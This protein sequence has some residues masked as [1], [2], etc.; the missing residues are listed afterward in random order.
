MVLTPESPKMGAYMH[1]G[2]AFY[3]VERWFLFAAAAAAC[4]KCGGCGQAWNEA[5]TGEETT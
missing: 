3:Q 1:R 2:C 5:V 4:Q